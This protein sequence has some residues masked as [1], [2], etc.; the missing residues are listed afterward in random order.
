MATWMTHFRIADYFLDRIDGIVPEPFIVGNIGPDC[1]V[2]NA[3]WSAFTPPTETTHWR[4]AWKDCRCNDFY[5][6]YLDYGDTSPETRSFL[7]GYYIHLLADNEWDR[8]IYRPKRR[9]Y[10]AQFARDKGFIWRFK[11]DW[12]VLDHLYLREHPDFRAFRV[13]ASIGDFHDDTLAYYPED[14][15][16]RQIGCIT[17]FYREYDGELD[18][19]YMYLNRQEM[20]D[21]VEKA[22]II[23]EGDLAG[24]GILP[25]P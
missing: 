20:D 21:F 2:P 5:A 24:K 25:A 14:A 6:A 7:L 12:Y 10:K 17:R 8:L 23:I 15:Y 3:D 13:F 11:G 16:T 1:G 22:V 19:E 18:H 9:E 4:E